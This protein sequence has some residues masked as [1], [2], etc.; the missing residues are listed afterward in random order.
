MSWY[1][2]DSEVCTKSPAHALAIALAL[3]SE[4]GPKMIGGALSEVQAGL[5]VQTS[6]R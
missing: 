4:S 1:A 2:M 3:G 6:V 5:S